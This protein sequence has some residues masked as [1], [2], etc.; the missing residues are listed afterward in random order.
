MNYRILYLLTNFIL[1]FCLS[2]SAFAVDEENCLLCHKYSGLGRIDETGKKHLYYINENL[3]NQSVH[4]R[5]RC[6]ECHTGI[7][8]FPHGTI[9]KVDCATLCHLTEPSS[10]KPF[11]HA[12]MIEKYQLSVHGT[13][14][15][16]KE[17]QHV[18]DLPTCTYC[19]ENTIYHEDDDLYHRG[20][21]V[22]REVMD[23]CLG[24][25]ANNAWTDTFFHHFIER[26]H[27]RRS[28]QRMVALCTSCHDNEER[29]ARHGLKTVGTFRDTFHWQAIKFGDPNAP[30]CIT[31]HAPVGYLAHDIMPKDD[32]SSAINKKNLV[33]TCSNQGGGQLCH[34]NATPRF[35]QG[36]VHP[37]QFKAGLFDRAKESLTLKQSI[38]KEKTKPFQSLLESIVRVDI[39]ERHP[40][41]NI[42]L[43]L[44]KYF[45]ML[46]IGILISS[47]I[48]HQIL[49]YFATL[50]EMRAGR[51]HHEQQ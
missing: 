20:G 15:Q 51:H 12:P 46:L 50:R 17:K 28:S 35:A 19:H 41:Q 34:P 40:Y 23:R 21:E 33:R 3:Y 49:D 14:E 29:M 44:V 25:H 36:E 47:M 48:I 22:I 43:V 1:F 32:I 24:C 7:D 38:D 5:I 4:G 9:K 8:K 10:G 16:G 31:C 13:M 37:I 30:N 2:S 27:Q 26:L 42:I 11:S 6:G 39:G 45:Y 18:E